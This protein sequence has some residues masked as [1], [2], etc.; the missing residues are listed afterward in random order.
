MLTAQY[1]LNTIVERNTS[2]LGV[3]RNYCNKLWTFFEDKISIV[4]I[5]NTFLGRETEHRSSIYPVDPLNVGLVGDN[6]I[7]I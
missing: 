7:Y 3:K 2:L 4:M 6:Y 1:Q 5:S